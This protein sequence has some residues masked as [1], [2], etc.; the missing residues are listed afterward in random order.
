MVVPW[1]VLLMGVVAADTAPGELISLSQ[2]GAES[3]P[4][5]I[6]KLIGSD[7][8]AGCTEVKYEGIDCSTNWFEACGEIDPP[9]GYIASALVSHI[10]AP[11]AVRQL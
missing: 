4:D 5:K 6:C 9:T 11:T 2:D 8:S 3:V 7:R 1:A 10:A